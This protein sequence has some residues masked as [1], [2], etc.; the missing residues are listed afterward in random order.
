MN[1]KLSVFLLMFLFITSCGGGK[2]IVGSEIANPSMS[3]KDII[4]THDDAQ[5]DFSII[6]ARMH[7]VY[8]RDNDIQQMLLTINTGC[9]PK[10]SFIILFILYL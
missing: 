5:S 4:K 7:V 9:N 6:A 2:M 8:E 1:L 10:C 3:S